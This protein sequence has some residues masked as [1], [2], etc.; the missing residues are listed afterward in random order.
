MGQILFTEAPVPSQVLPGLSTALDAVCGKAMAKAP[1]GRYPSMKEFAAALADLQRT[2]P[3]KEPAGAEVAPNK[4]GKSAADIF[5]LP[6]TALEPLPVPKR[7]PENRRQPA[8]SQTIPWALPADEPGAGKSRQERPASAIVSDEQPRAALPA[9]NK[10]EPESQPEMKRPDANLI[11]RAGKPTSKPST[12]QPSPGPSV[13]AQAVESRVDE[14]LKEFAAIAGSAEI[15]PAERLREMLLL[16]MGNIG[17]RR[18]YLQLR[19]AE[20]YDA[21]YRDVRVRRGWFENCLIVMAMVSATVPGIVFWHFIDASIWGLSC[22]LIPMGLV[23][24]MAFMP[25]TTVINKWC[26]LGPLPLEAYRLSRSQARR[27]YLGE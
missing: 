2:L 10:D 24:C 23:C 25:N 11:E 1:E 8:S 26:E 20:L 15:E 12:R 14:L 5:D 3:A 4:G 6:T 21:D 13:P 7:P 16:D 17:L 18:S 9:T 19:T 22:C 27:K